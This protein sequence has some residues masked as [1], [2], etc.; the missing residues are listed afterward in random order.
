MILFENW[1]YVCSFS[2]IQH[3]PL[4]NREHWKINVKIGTISI[5]HSLRKYAGIPSS[6]VA[7]LCGFKLCNKLGTPST[8]IE[9]SDIF[10]KESHLVQAMNSSLP[11]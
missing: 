9:I 3:K 10:G 11:G 4:L 5:E 8:E 2:F 1:D 6:P 7:L